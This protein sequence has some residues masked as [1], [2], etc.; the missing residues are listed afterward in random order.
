VSGKRRHTLWARLDAK[1]AEAI[2]A[3]AR[4]DQRAEQAATHINT[5]RASEMPCVSTSKETNQ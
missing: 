5:N 3:E 2:A 1:I 4:R